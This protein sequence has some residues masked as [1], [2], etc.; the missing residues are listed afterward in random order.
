VPSISAFTRGADATGNG[1]AFFAVS[2]N[3]RLFEPAV[4]GPADL[5]DPL[6]DDI[7]EMVRSVVITAEPRDG[8]A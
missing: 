4:S 2:Q 8:A 7:E 5:A 6:Y 3:D 1:S